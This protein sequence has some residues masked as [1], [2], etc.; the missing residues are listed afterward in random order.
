MNIIKKRSKETVKTLIE[1]SPNVE[2]AD[3]I[4]VESFGYKN[5]EQKIMFLEEMFD[6]SNI[7]NEKKDNNTYFAMLSA[8]IENY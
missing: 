5:T 3:K 4:I 6:V 7:S 8:I 2:T 1:L